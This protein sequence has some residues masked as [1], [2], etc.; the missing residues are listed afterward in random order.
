[1]STAAA[2]N[3]AQSASTAAPP[4]TRAE[5]AKKL[6]T[7]NTYWAMGLGLIPIPIADIVALTAV[8]VKML[9]ELSDL[10]QVKFFEE[11]A[12]T[13]IGSLVTGLG[14]VG[15]GRTLAGSLF[16]LVPVVG[17]LLSVAGVPLL[18]GASTKAIGNLFAMHYESGGTL[19]DFDAAKMREYFAKEFE[20]AKE[21]LAK[22]KKQ[23]K[24]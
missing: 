19:L 15:V 22:D 14:S 7:R 5:Q 11:K 4:V 17:P 2:A 1:M 20:Q 13:V 18:A 23:D 12:K 21:T 16:K 24:T 3:P 6:I 8:Q 9:K 10:Y